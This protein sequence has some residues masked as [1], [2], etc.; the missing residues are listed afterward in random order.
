MKTD[1]GL[2]PWL[3]IWVEPK[4]T[5]RKIINYNPN[6]RLFFLS[7]IYGFVSLVSSSERFSLGLTMH[8]F[9]VL[10]LCLIIAPIWG[11]IVFS[12]SSFFIYFIGKWLKGRAK[13]IEVRSAIAWS[14]VPMLV[15]IFMWILL[16]I[17]FGSDLFRDFP[18]AFVLTKAQKAF[19]FLIL[20]S[21]LVI[22]IWIIVLYVNALSE[23]QKF[24]IGKAILN[25]LIAI[26]I[27]PAVIALIAFIYFLIMKGL[28]LR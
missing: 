10:L 4:A 23:V 1:L 22:S 2:N 27:V 12:I 11:Y 26:V 21:Q 5:I 16:F 19:L 17:I 6:F 9:W 8:F 18:G 25:I 28:H 15:N 3:K 13:F 7:A 14:N 20:L 24:S